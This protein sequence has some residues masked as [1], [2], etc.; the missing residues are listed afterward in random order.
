M[1]LAEGAAVTATD[2]AA[3]ASAR[4]NFPGLAIVD[5]PYSATVGADAIV[6][7]TDWEDYRTLDLDHVA[8]AMRGHLIVDARGCLDA[9]SAEAAGLGYAGI[10]YGAKASLPA[11]PALHAGTSVCRFAPSAVSMAAD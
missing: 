6:I 8:N 3:G 11:P 7:M 4:T 2:P 10:G 5:D 1:L 9:P